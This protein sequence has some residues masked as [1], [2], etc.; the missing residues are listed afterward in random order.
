MKAELSQQAKGKYRVGGD[1]KKGVW[2]E[3]N[4]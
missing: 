4:Q 1:E 3:N 2:E